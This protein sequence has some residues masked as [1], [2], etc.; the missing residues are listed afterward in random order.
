VAHPLTGLLNVDPR[1]ESQILDKATKRHHNTHQ[2]ENQHTVTQYNDT[3]HNHIQYSNKT[4][5]TLSIIKLK[6]T[7]HIFERQYAE[8]HYVECLG[9]LQELAIFLDH[10][11]RT[12]K[13]K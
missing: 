2:N 13:V 10:Q 4:N 12:K 5:A 1:L 7:Y 9:A 3:R 6:M 11:W 8:S